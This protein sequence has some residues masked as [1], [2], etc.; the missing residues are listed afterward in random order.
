MRYS[1]LVAR[2]RAAAPAAADVDEVAAVLEASGVNDRVAAEGYGYPS[3]FALAEVVHALAEPRRAGPGVRRDGPRRTREV[4]DTLVRAGLH[5]TPTVLAIGAAHR[6]GGLPRYAT[7][8]LLVAGWSFA[9]ALAFL[10]YRV[11]GVSGRA[12][13]ARPVALGFGVFAAVWVGVLA[14]AGAGPGAW[15]VGAAQVAL[16]AA[17]TAALVTGQERR[18]L[19]AALGCWAAAGLFATGQVRPGVVALGAGLAAML[20]LAY[21]PA[22]RTPARWPD[23]RAYPA[24]LRHGLVG[25]GQALLFVVVVLAPGGRLTLAVPLLVGVPLTELLLVWHQRRVADGRARLADRAAFTDRLVRAA[26]GSAVALALPLAGGLALLGWPRLAGTVLLAGLY[27]ICLVLVAHRR[28]LSAA[29]LMW[30]P[31]L[32]LVAVPLEPAAV[33]LC[34]Y[35][36]GL[37]LAFPA[38]RD[39]ASYQ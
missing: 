7:I 29:G 9:Q 15:L 24:A 26:A 39:P 31:A 4:F 19:A 33:L 30:W 28:P 16:F 2:A 34:A 3:V 21:R 8:G 6:L 14:I 35:P 38:M 27:A 18:T 36:A 13:A 1:T 23:R 20:A 22:V 5:L 32:V 12:A 10:G 11:A 17:N 25:A 37:L